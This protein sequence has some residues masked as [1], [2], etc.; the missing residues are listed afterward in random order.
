MS[1]ELYGDEP[2]PK[3]KAKRGRKKAVK[4]EASEETPEEAETA[5]AE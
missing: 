3:P 2:E 4:A 5:D 1:K